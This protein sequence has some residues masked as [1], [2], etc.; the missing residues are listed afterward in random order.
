MAKKEKMTETE[1]MQQAF[2]ALEMLPKDDVPRVLNWLIAKLN[3]QM[4]AGTLAISNTSP[5]SK[6]ALP[7]GHITSPQLFMDEKNPKTDAE[8]VTCL[9]YYLTDFMQAP[10]F[11]SLDISDANKK[12][13][14]PKLSN[15][16]V[17]LN[18][19][20]HK[21]QFLA[22]VGGGKKQLTSRGRRVVD[23]LPDRDKVNDVL[24]KYPIKGHR[25][26]TKK[27]KQ[28]KS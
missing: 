27:G 8:R 17:A 12:A 9:A 3:V 5:L 26:K 24:V 13:A 7:S 19:A 14:Q 23:A 15:V 4:Q 11:K 25:K 18:D 10:S 16:T 20:T 6:P 28:V 22:V 1:V 21:Y 2:E